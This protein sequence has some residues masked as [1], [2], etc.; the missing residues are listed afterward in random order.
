MFFFCDNFY[1][2][3]MLVVGFYPKRDFYKSSYFKNA[4]QACFGFKK[5]LI[6]KRIFNKTKR[7]IRSTDI[8]EIFSKRLNINEKQTKNKDFKKIINLI[9]K[10][11]PNH[12]SLLDLNAKNADLCCLA[13][14]NN[15]DAEIIGASCQERD[16]N[17]AVFFDK[18]SQTDILNLNFMFP[19]IDIERA[20]KL[21]KSDIVVVY[22]VFEKYCIENTF[23]INFV[24]NCIKKYARKFVYILISDFSKTNKELYRKKI[25]KFFDIVHEEETENGLGC[26]FVLKTKKN[27][28]IKAEKFINKYIGR[29]AKGM[30]IVIGIGIVAAIMLF[31]FINKKDRQ[32]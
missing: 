17:T 28:E 3:D 12:N 19:K 4:F 23:D 9:N 13:K 1:L 31:I 30:S 11:S 21:L 24:L 5:S 26:I 27:W 32:L 8:E 18:N 10:Y 29:D 14:Q 25:N 15:P 2:G 6:F 7:E 20:S 16:K 22:D